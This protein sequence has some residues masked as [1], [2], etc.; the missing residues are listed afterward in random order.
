M[1]PKITL[2][3]VLIATVIGLSYLTDANIDRLRRQFDLSRWRGFMPLRR[4]V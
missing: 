1:D 3:L 2:L 4:R